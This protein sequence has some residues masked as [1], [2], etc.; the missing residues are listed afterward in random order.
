MS[1]FFKSAL[2][3]SV[4]SDKTFN[5]QKTLQSEALSLNDVMSEEEIT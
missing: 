1:D 3:R 4:D 2:K 5:K